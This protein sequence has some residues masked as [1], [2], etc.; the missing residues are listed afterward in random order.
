MRQGNNPRRG[1]GRSGRRP[2]VPSR[3]FNYESNGPEGRVRGNAAQ[4]YEKYLQLARDAQSGGDRVLGESFMQHAEHYY[5]ILNESSDPGSRVHPQRETRSHERVDE[6]ERDED[7]ALLSESG[8]Q[9]VIASRSRVED[10][11][12]QARSDDPRYSEANGQREEEASAEEAADEPLETAAEAEATEAAEEVKAAPSSETADA[13]E[14]KSEAEAPKPA[15][16]TR[17]TPVRRSTKSKSE[18][19]P[20]GEED[21]GLLKMLGESP[22]ANG[23]G[24]AKAET[25]AE[26]SEEAAAEQPAQEAEPAKPRRRRT[27]KSSGETAAKVE[28]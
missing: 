11:R 19:A 13:S 20:S 8:E 15:R 4:V 28:A 9:S 10:R 24:T 23:K 22:R 16:R 27:S 12:Q 26:A 14:G 18:A 5:R 3:S 17:R 2:N 25:A 6:R 21:A 7:E 1:R